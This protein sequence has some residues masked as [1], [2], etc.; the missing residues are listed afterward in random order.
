MTTEHEIADNGGPN[1][2]NAVTAITELLETV[3]GTTLLPS[4][5]SQIR[6]TMGASN[7]VLQGTKLIAPQSRIEE[8]LDRSKSKQE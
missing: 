3:F 6:L 2:I 7:Q 1:A 8:Y 5:L 4:A